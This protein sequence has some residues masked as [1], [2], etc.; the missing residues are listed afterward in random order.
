[1]MT[2]GSSPKYLT[3]F[4][5]WD[6]GSSCWRTSQACLFQDLD[7]FLENWP[8]SGS[9]RSGEV[10]PVPIS[11]QATG[12]NESLSWPTPVASDGSGNRSHPGA[13]FRPSLRTL[14]KK[15]PTPTA[16]DWKRAGPCDHNHHSPNLSSIDYHFGHP[17][18]PQTGPQSP[19]PI[20]RL[21]SR[22]VQWLMGFPD[23]WTSPTEQPDLRHWETQCRHLLRPWLGE[24]SATESGAE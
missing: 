6:R 16:R 3:S 4:A 18:P 24:S 13:P 20:G 10:F 15:W 5:R 14:G 23:M 21:N 9:M 11:A 8:K 12:E 2:A 7:A 19:P 1:M 22:F 17:G